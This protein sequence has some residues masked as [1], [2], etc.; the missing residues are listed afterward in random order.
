MFRFMLIMYDE[1]S[2]IRL[3]ILEAVFCLQKF[4]QRVFFGL[5]D[6]YILPYIFYLNSHDDIPFGNEEYININNFSDYIMIKFNIHCRV[7]LD[8]IAL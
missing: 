4:A 5:D 8:N 6:I 7:F 3:V 1:N 2:S